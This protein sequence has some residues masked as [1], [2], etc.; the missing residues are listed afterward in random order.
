MSEDLT[1]TCGICKKQINAIADSNSTIIERQM[2]ELNSKSDLM[3]YHIETQC[4]ENEIHLNLIVVDRDGRYRGLKHSE[5]RASRRINDSVLN[6]LKD[7]LRFGNDLAKGISV[8]LRGNGI[9]VCGE[10]E[11]CNKFAEVIPRCFA[12]DSY[13]IRPWISSIQDFV[14]EYG[15]SS[16]ISPRTI[17]LLDSGLMRQVIQT[18]T[19]APRMELR[20]RTVVGADALP[21]STNLLKM[22]RA[23]PENEH[24]AMQA[25]LDT[26]LSS[27]QKNLDLLENTLRT[28]LSE[29]MV[30]RAG[31]LSEVEFLNQILER[32]L[33]PQQLAEI[34]TSIRPEDFEILAPHLTRRIPELSRAMGYTT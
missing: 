26:Q 25:L 19:E 34:R 21:F 4:N 22:L 6:N 9:A 8:T 32:V 16:M 27:L 33:S 14:K 12:L 28:P 15:N 20:N 3:T 1:F 24:R 30:V 31:D 5:V 17:A 13:E 10:E 18:L 29:T 2:P 11:Q 7:V 23:V